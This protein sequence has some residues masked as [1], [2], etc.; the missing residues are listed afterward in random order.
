[1]LIPFQ[2]KLSFLIF[3]HRVTK[4][5][6]SLYI[7]NLTLHD[8]H[9]YIEMILN[10][11]NRHK[12]YINFP[13]TLLLL[14]HILI[15]LPMENQLSFNQNKDRNRNN[16]LK[17]C[18]LFLGELSLCKGLDSMD[19]PSVLNLS[20]IDHVAVHF[21]TIFHFYVSDMPKELAKE[22]HIH[23]RNNLFKHGNCFNLTFLLKNLLCFILLRFFKNKFVYPLF[24][25][26]K[27]QLPLKL[28]LSNPLFFQPR[29]PL[30][31]HILFLLC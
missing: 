27:G 20:T 21:S 1:M 11:P 30:Q 5:K 2:E 17:T 3:T 25:C 22:L 29:L 7:P 14:F 13:C 31:H 4:P 6:P 18:P 28:R 19:F 15:H 8:I 16:L 10:I 23:S 12:E 24:I 26:K 9:L